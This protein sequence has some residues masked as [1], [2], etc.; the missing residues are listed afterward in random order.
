[1]IT[2]YILFHGRFFVHSLTAIGRTHWEVL[3][4]NLC[5]AIYNFSIFNYY[6][7]LFVIYPFGQDYAV[8]LRIIPETQGAFLVHDIHVTRTLV[9]ESMFYPVLPGTASTLNNNSV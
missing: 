3:R 8:T 2:H 1:G 7:L 4:L 9:C 5:V 6:V